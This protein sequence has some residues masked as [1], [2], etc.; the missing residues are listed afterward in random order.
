VF[1][2]PVREKNQVSPRI[3]PRYHFVLVCAARGCPPLLPVPFGFG[4]EML[5]YA[6]RN[7]LRSPRHFWWEEG[8]AHVS[9]IFTWYAADFGWTEGGIRGFLKRYAPIPDNVTEF[10]IVADIPW[11]WSLNEPE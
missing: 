3:D 6:V 1:L 8:R 11:D 4:D 5:D 7:A 10:E 9:Q 2:D